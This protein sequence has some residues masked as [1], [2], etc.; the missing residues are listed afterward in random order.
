MIYYPDRP[1]LA[2]ERGQPATILACDACGTYR[3]S[4]VRSYII[5]RVTD[6]LSG[7]PIYADCCLD[8]RLRGRLADLA[9]DL[10]SGWDRSSTLYPVPIDWTHQPD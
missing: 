10:I 7:R 6:P 3:A 9:A 1:G 5:A 8:C 2:I 4:G